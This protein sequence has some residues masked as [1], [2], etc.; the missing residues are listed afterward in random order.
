MSVRTHGLGLRSGFVVER[1]GASSNPCRY[2]H[3]DHHDRALC[4]R[5]YRGG[6]CANKGLELRARRKLHQ[7]AHP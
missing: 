4:V 7:H 5:D 3:Q 2:A 6:W 1:L